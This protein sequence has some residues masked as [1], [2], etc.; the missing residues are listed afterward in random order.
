ML[1]STHSMSLNRSQYGGCSTKTHLAY[2]YPRDK[3]TR[4]GNKSVCTN[5][6]ASPE[7]SYNDNVTRGYIHRISAMISLHLACKPSSR[8]MSL[9]RSQYGSCSTKY[10][11]T[12]G[13]WVV[14]GRFGTSAFA[15]KIGRQRQQ[16]LYHCL[17]LSTLWL[18]R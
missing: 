9:N 1:T 4:L 6:I 3:M 8:W 15:Y 11:T 10:N 14:Y 16:L 12:T 2:T 5:K 13:T 18:H 7:I 17:T